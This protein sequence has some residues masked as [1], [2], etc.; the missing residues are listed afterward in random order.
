[1]EPSIHSVQS[2]VELME[3]RPT[4]LENSRRFAAP[5]AASTAM[6]S[7]DRD[8]DD[9]RGPRD[10]AARGAALSRMVGA[11]HAGGAGSGI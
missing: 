11:R 2:S 8:V 9:V 5:S 7:D 1:M 10:H 3:A 4:A 6:G